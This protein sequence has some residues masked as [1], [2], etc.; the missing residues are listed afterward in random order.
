M[1]PATKVRK[2][3][4]CAI[5]E[6]RL[7]CC[8]SGL[9][10]QDE[11]RQKLLAGGSGTASKKPAIELD[12]TSIWIQI[13]NFS[14][15][16]LRLEA[17]SLWLASYVSQLHVASQRSAATQS[18][19]YAPQVPHHHQSTAQLLRQC[20]I[21]SGSRMHLNMN[22]QSTRATAVLIA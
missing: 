7:L 21:A 22:P 6:H 2:A 17:R 12:A 13:I 5:S 8:S 10:V 9:A 20:T 1:R 15:R 4:V 14:M 16:A 19:A 18:S 11:H 3:S